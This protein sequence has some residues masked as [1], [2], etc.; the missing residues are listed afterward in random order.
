MIALLAISELSEAQ[1][2]LR[3][4]TPYEVPFQ[5]KILAFTVRIGFFNPFIPIFSKFELEL[6]TLC[7]TL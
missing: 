7:G 3:Q 5:S 2:Q 1:Q 6:E 4:G